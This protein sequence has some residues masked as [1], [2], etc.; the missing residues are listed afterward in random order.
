[1]K[2]GV[3]GGEGFIGGHL[4]ESLVAQGHRVFVLGNHRRHLTSL[5]TGVVFNTG[6]IRSMRDVQRAF[7][8]CNAIVNLAAESSVMRCEGDKTY[9]RTTNVGGVRNLAYFALQM[10]I[11]IVQ[12]SSREVYGEQD[13]LPVTEETPFGAKNVYGRS[14]AAAERLL[15]DCPIDTAILRFAN[16]T[17]TR[18]EGRLLPLWLK[19]ASEG[20]P[21]TVFGGK[22]LIDF[23]PVEVVVRAIEFAIDHHIPYPVNIGSGRAT[24]ILELAERIQ[25]IVPGTKINLLPPREAEVTGYQADIDRMV[26]L[27]IQPPADPLENLLELSQHYARVVSEVA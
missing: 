21:L 18:D 22:Q 12:A 9:A 13:T 15:Q 6:D 5:P 14:K 16:V 17:G 4:I 1:M 25:E 19:A 27:G 11:K 20:R 3:T 23:V 26:S 2:I 7:N 10:D 24:P 8:G